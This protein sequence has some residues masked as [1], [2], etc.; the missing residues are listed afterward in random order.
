[1]PRELFDQVDQ[2][3]EMAATIPIVRRQSVQF[4][5][6]E[7]RQATI[8]EHAEVV[9]VGIQLGAAQGKSRARERPLQHSDPVGVAG[10][11]HRKTAPALVDHFRLLG[12]RTWRRRP[13]LEQALDSQHQQEGRDPE[14]KGGK[15][16]N[17]DLDEGIVRHRGSD[18]DRRCGRQTESD[19][20]TPNDPHTLLPKEVQPVERPLPV[21]GKVAHL[22]AKDGEIDGRIKD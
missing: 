12:N 19:G 15:C 10:C 2:F 11:N 1:M 3:I 21:I 9:R 13:T 5:I 4:P 7:F 6:D 16:R 8:D 22:P 14:G 20:E 18:G 17:Q